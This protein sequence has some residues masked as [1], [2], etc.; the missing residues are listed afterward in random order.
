MSLYKRKDS[1]YWWVKLSEN[2]ESLQKSTGTADRKQAKEL[3]AKWRTELWEQRRLGKKPSHLWDEAVLRYL[4]EMSHKATAKDDRMILRWWQKHFEGSHLSSINRA[5]LDHLTKVAK[6]EGIAN[7]TVNRRLAVLRALLKKAADEWEWLDRVPKVRM[8]PVSKGRTRFLTPPEAQRLLRELPEHLRSMM[9]FALCTGLRQGNIKRLKWN[10]VD[11]HRQTAWI[12][13]HESKSRKAI[14]VPLSPD[15]VRILEMEQGKH[16]EYVFTYQGEPIIQVATKAWRAALERA[17]IEDF[18]FHD[19]RHTF[20]TW[21][22][23]SGTSL[24]ELQALGGWASLDMVQRYAHMSS[25]HLARSAQ[26]YSEH[27]PMPKIAGS[28]DLATL[29]IQH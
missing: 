3:E 14:A 19:L 2:G 13:A 8:L 12:H 4:E 20:A 21:H 23:Q 1:P 9:A 5:T 16:S 18:R 26:R 28:Y 6:A 22:V 17:G 7:A 27:F 29:E 10:Q 25:A 24:I 15:A 11:V